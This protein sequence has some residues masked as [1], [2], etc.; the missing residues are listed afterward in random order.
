MALLASTLI[1]DLQTT[2]GTLNATDQAVLLTH[3]Q[4]AADELYQHKRWTWRRLASQ[5][6]SQAP[7]TTGT[8][9]VSAGSTAVVGTST[10]WAGVTDY[11]TGQFYI[12]LNGE[13]HHVSSITDNTN[14]VLTAG[15][16]TA[17][18][19]ATY[20]LY[21]SEVVL[22]ST[23]AELTAVGTQDHPNLRIVSPAR[24][25]EL[26][27]GVGYQAYATHCSLGPL[28][29]KVRTID[30]FPFPSERRVYWYEGYT[31]APTLVTT[32]DLG[33]PDNFRD[34]VANLTLKRWFSARDFNPE[35]ASHAESAAAR[36][37]NMLAE[38]DAPDVAPI[39]CR[40]VFGR[41]R[42]GASFRSSDTWVDE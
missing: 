20:G 16:D 17:V 39:P 42:G 35:R 1:T 14:L 27:D 2:I 37:L 26:F 29:S 24:A 9:T 6:T 28:S 41:R 33:C 34:V 19:A 8:V 25:R 13:M 11:S 18:S 32:T 21:R 4:R 22:D 10:L 40:G 5:F 36:S 15:V 23:L 31:D 38:R 7:Y 12:Q 30:L 3:L